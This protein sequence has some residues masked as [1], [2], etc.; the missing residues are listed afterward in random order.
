MPFRRA[1][2]LVTVEREGVID[3]FVYPLSGTAPVIKLPIKPTYAP[4]AFVSVM[5]V[6]GRTDDVKPTALIDLGKPA[7][8]MGV[9]EIEVGWRVHELNVQLRP[10]RETYKVRDKVRVALQVTQRQG[11]KPVRG[12]EV[13]LAAVDEGAARPRCRTEL[14]VA[15]RDDGRARHRGGYLHRADAGGRQ[16]PLR[17]QGA[18][19]RAA[20]AGASATG[21]ELFDSLLAW[22][23]ARATRRPNGE[24]SIEVPAERFADRVPRRR[25]RRR[26]HRS[27]FG[28]GERDDPHHAGPAC[29]VSGLPPLVREGDRFAATFTVRNTSAARDARPRSSGSRRRPRRCR[30]R[31]ARLGGGQARDDCLAR[32]APAGAVSSMGNHSLDRA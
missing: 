17:P 12:T 8:K 15:R 24:A 19:A 23:G 30:R 16:A 5:V 6:R 25:D 14:A 22:Q 3:S 13:A 2:A 20:A 4:N 1:T 21:R 28:T 32:V 9:T 29:C 26:R 18:A 31:G 10:E 27:M 11:G 7:F